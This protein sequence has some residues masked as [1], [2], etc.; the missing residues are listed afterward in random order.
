MQKVKQI[1]AQEKS[2][3]WGGVIKGALIALSLSLILILIFAFVMRFISI[4]DEAIKP[5]NQVIKIASVMLGTIMGLKKTKEM[6][7]I[8]GL[9]V[10]I[11]YTIIAFLAFS[12]LD[13]NFSFSA[14]LV[15]D[16][17]FGGVTGA[18]CGIIAVNFKKK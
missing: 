14:T 4:S 16:L 2:P 17:L 18:I 5:I 10:G 6:G 3:F 15:N 8:S 12:I 13:G 1:S 7:L 11:L 9:L